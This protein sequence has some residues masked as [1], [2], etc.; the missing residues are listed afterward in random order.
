MKKEARAFVRNATLA[1]GLVIPPLVYPLLAH[2]A[3]AHNALNALKPELYSCGPD[4]TIQNADAILVPGGGMYEDTNGVYRP[5]AH[6]RQRL[7][8]AAILYAQNP[9]AKIVLLLG[10][11]D[12]GDAMLGQANIDYLQRAYQWAVEAD[13]MIPSEDIVVDNRSINTATNMQEAVRI[14]KQHSLE[15]FLLV[16]QSYHAERAT[17]FACNNGLH[18]TPALVE[19][20]LGLGER[21]YP[22]HI[23]AKESIELALS[24]W[25]PQGNLQTY[26]K[27]QVS[28][29]VY[30]PTHEPDIGRMQRKET[31]VFRYHGRR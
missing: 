25:D 22:D 10:V 24:Y 18:V 3:E 11:P 17:L 28:G 30:E 27:E 23:V 6:T 15:R 26:M 31:V 20:V 19:D 13:D 9:D 14:A 8:A 1:A 4:V 5:N 16:T 7:R 29:R 2:P 12:E 21:T